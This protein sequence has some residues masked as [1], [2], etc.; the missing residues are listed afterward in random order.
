[1]TTVS[2][3]EKCNAFTKYGNRCI[4]CEVTSDEDKARYNGLVNYGLVAAPKVD[5]E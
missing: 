1:M 3:C 4:I 2:L 5:I